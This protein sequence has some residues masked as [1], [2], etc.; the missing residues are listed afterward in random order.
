MNIRKY[1]LPALLGSCLLLNSTA[2][3]STYAST[4]VAQIPVVASLEEGLAQELTDFRVPMTKENSN[5]RYL[6]G[7]YEYRNVRTTTENDK[8]LGYHPNFPNWLKTSGYWF[9]T[10]TTSWS[11]SG[12]YNTKLNVSINVGLNGSTSANGL[13]RKADE[14]RF[15]RPY[16]TADITYKLADMYT[17]DD[18]NNLLN[19]VRGTC[20]SHSTSDVQY[21]VA[22]K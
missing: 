19:V 2:Y 7:Y 20:I 10:K 5:A 17:Y 14:N 4:Q 1:I 21:F 9:S 8:R 15:S 3:A 13:W 11:V 12:A 6:G 16:V 18:F 22:Y